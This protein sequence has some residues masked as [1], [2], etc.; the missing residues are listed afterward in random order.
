[1]EHIRKRLI[2][3]LVQD[4]VDEINTDVVDKKYVGFVT[5][6]G[7]AYTFIPTKEGGCTFS[8]NCKGQLFKIVEGLAN[9]QK[10]L[11]KLE[12]FGYIDTYCEECILVSLDDDNFEQYN[13]FCI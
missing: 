8:N 3:L 2:Q 12:E 13:N 5:S 7:A 4:K 11:E 10:D 6:E 9:S 1:M